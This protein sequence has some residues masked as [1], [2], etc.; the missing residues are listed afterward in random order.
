MLRKIFGG[1]TLLSLTGAIALGVVFAAPWGATGTGSG[2]NNI[3]MASTNVVYEE[4]IMGDGTVTHVIVGPNDNI[5]R[6]V[7]H[8]EMYNHSNSQYNLVSG[9]GSVK[10]DGVQEDPNGNPNTQADDGQCL[11]QDFAGDV[12]N[13]STTPVVPGA[14]DPLQGT[15]RIAVLS[16]AAP[17]CQGKIVSFTATI[18][19]QL[20]PIS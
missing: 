12:Q 20:A 6:P 18:N 11:I 2:Q 7:G 5:Y 16:T 10:I 8:V 15:V 4:D 9:T 3:G 14:H 17:S 19:A 13:I 1:A